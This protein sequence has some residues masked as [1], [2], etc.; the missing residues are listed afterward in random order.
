MIVIEQKYLNSVNQG[1]VFHNFF[2]TQC[3]SKHLPIDK[4]RKFY[5]SSWR[6]AVGRKSRPDNTR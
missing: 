4:P 5:Y 1:P 2:C 3:V 6:L